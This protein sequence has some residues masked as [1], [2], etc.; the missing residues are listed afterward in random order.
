MAAGKPVSRVTETKARE[1]L[2][3]ILRKTLAY[4]PHVM[5]CHFTLTAG[6]VMPEHHH[7][8]AQVGYVVRGK[9]QFRSGDRSFAAAAGTGYAFE[10]NEPHGATAEEDT[11]VIECFTPS[12]PEYQD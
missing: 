9:L 5:L 1:A 12:R 3:G 10:P 11:E 7:E 6:A 2:P 8:A 4:N